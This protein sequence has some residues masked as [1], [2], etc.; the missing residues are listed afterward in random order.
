M[1]ESLNITCYKCKSENVKQEEGGAFRCQNCEQQFYIFE[2]D[3]STLNEIQNCFLKF[4]FTSVK[5]LESLAPKGAGFERGDIVHAGF[6]AY[7]LLQMEGMDWVERKRKALAFA[8][9]KAA[10]SQLEVEDIMNVLESIKQYFD[11][12]KADSWKPL[13]VEHCFRKLVYEDDEL[14]LILSGKIDM[15]VD[16]GPRNN[17]LELPV[18]HKSGI[19]VAPNELSNQ[20]MAYSHVS[21]SNLFCVNKVGFQ[22]TVPMDKKFKRHIIPYTP[23]LLEHWLKNSIWWI[24]MAL[25]CMENSSF[26]QNFTSCDKYSGC[27]F[28]PV[29]YSKPSNM[30][31]KLQSLFKKRDKPWDPATADLPREELL[32]VLEKL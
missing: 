6:H 30:E 4:N 27:Q 9:M 12:Y 18:D 1:T 14:K 20:F 10:E 23:D 17:N 26:P 15:K 7:Y 16:T 28:K 31:F 19:D 22:K 3:P 24:K 25:F 32:K 13:V 2:T 11:Y 5:Q 8:E 21:K 29:C